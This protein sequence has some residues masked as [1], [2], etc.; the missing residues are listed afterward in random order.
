MTDAVAQATRIIYD[1][2]L[3][4]YEHL[5]LADNFINDAYDPQLAAAEILAAVNAREPGVSPAEALLGFK[6]DWHRLLQ[7]GESLFHV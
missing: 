6:R 4:P 5:I 3:S 7:L 1:A 2:D